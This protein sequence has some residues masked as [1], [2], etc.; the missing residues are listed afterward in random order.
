M[1]KQL[2][3]KAEWDDAMKSGKVTKTFIQNQFCII[4]VV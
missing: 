1:V 3:T 4:V 2:A